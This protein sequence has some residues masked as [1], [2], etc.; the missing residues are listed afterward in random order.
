MSSTDPA[1]QAKESFSSLTLDPELLQLEADELQFYKHKTGIENEQELKRHIVEVQA[2]AYAVYP[3]P[4]IR[5]F[6]FTKLKI[7]R[8][9]GYNQLLKLG[10]ERPGALFLD[11]GCCFG[12]DVRKALDDGFPAK[13]AIGSD[14]QPEFWELGYRLFRDSAE[15]FPVP[16]IPGDAFDD[17]FLAVSPPEG[18][19][20]NSPLPEISTLKSL[21]PLHGRLSAIH[22]SSFFHLFNEEKQALLAHKLASLLSPEPGSIIFGAHG[23]QP[24]KGNR[25]SF[26]QNLKE[27][28]M[29]CHSPESWTELWEKEVFGEGEVK[30]TAVL[31]E[32]ERKDMLMYENNKFCVLIWSVERLK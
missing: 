10:K 31:R 9:L 26:R 22:A 1:T 2:D 30:V 14:L 3:Y 13:Q 23:G 16:F 27:V 25:K 29:F 18:T 8:L 5:S 4:C 20:F 11:I 32:V 15:T 19:D 6:A 24:V 12:N 21:N 7:S 17:E 28:V